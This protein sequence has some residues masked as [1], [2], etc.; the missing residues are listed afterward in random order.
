MEVGYRHIDGAYF[1]EKEVGRAIREK[2]TDGMVKREEIFYPGKP[3]STF[4]TP[5]MVLSALE[6]SLKH[7]QFDH[8]ALCIIHTPLSLKTME[9]C[10]DTELVKSIGVSNFNIRQLEMI[11]NKPG[12]KYKPVLKL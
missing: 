12:L 1:Y 3:W 8:I 10:K 2:I 11:L 5:E 7:L 9:A 6:K 4:N